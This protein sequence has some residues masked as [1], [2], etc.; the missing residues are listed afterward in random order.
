MSGVEKDGGA[1]WS[2]DASPQ[3]IAEDK[4]WREANERRI[5]GCIAGGLPVPPHYWDAEGKRLEHKALI[6]RSLTPKPESRDV[7]Q[8]QEYRAQVIDAFDRLD[9][10]EQRDFREHKAA[11]EY[12]GRK[13]L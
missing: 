8:R 3:Q 9:R 10:A 13:R 7:T 5:E 4:V 11:V 12:A 6:L 1:V 2:R